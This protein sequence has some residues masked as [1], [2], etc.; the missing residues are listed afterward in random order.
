MMILAIDAGNSRIK[1]GIH[2]GSEWWSLGSLPSADAARLSVVW[3]NQ[4]PPSKVIGCNVAGADPGRDIVQAVATLG[5]QIEWVSSRR[6][7]C[8]V[9][10]RYDDAEQLGADRW[11]GLIAARR[12]MQNFEG[13]GRG[14]IVLSAG[15]AVTIDALTS[16]GEFLGGVIIPGPLVM[17]DSLEKN[18][19]ALKRQA[20][21]FRLLPTNTADA[22]A[23]GAYLAVGGALARVEQALRRSGEHDCEVLITGGGAADLQP[24]LERNVTLIPNLVLEGLIVV[25]SQAG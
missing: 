5:C 12:R 15:T 18:T 23:T 1:W 11:I 7:Q 4:T 17:A 14:C 19:A 10:S 8:G 16:T 3:G 9:V 2:H 25:A 22:I 21:K 24:T 20:G 13:T 6:E